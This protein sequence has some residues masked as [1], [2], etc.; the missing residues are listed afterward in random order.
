M[1]WTGFESYESPQRRQHW[2]PDTNPHPSAI[3]PVVEIPVDEA[4]FAVIS[5]MGGSFD[6]AALVASM[7]VGTDVDVESDVEALSCLVMLKKEETNPSGV[8]EL[9][10]KKNLFE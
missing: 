5:E 7:A 2:Y 10:Q 4:D 1:G 9:T 8:S 3:F 6:G